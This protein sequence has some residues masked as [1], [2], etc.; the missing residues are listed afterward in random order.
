MG[1]PLHRTMAT[2]D[3]SIRAL[4]YPMA[5]A[6]LEGW[7]VVDCHDNAKVAIDRARN[8]SLPTLLEF[9]T[10]RYRGHSMAD[11]AK[12]RTKEEVA[13]WKRTKD[14]IALAKARLAKDHPELAIKIPEIDKRIDQEVAEAVEFA[15]NSPEPDPS[16]V[17]DYTYV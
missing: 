11:P 15:D 16:T 8:E 5:R 3:A 17:G 1:T 13:E 14:P 4:G 10:Y 12:Y 6:T 2:S 7:D 9:K